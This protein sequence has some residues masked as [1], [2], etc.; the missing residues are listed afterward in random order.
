MLKDGVGAAQLFHHERLTLG[1][2]VDITTSLN[3]LLKTVI[4][5]IRK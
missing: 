5:L 2:T 3:L 4:S 1:S